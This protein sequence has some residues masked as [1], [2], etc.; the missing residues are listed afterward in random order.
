MKAGEQV[1]SR[2]LMKAAR[3][4]GWRSGQP[5]HQVHS[6]QNPR[7]RE[8]RWGGVQGVCT[9]GCRLL[10]ETGLQ[11]VLNL[12]TISIMAGVLVHLPATPLFLP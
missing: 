8:P 1:E 11:P 12:H 10:Q 5:G 9:P 3:R 4:T 2:R 7:E 6:L